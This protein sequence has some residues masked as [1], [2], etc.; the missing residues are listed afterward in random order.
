MSLEKNI[1]LLMGSNSDNLWVKIGPMNVYLR[2]RPLI[3]I[4]NVVVR[5]KY[6]RKGH[7]TELVDYCENRFGQVYVEQVLNPILAGWLERRGY[8]EYR[9][10]NWR[11]NN[12]P[13]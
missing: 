12:E 2:K 7:F 3:T 11:M 10:F 8:T 6:Q 9:P 13:S 5:E 1:D 4:A